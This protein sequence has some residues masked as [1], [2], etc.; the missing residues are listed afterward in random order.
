[1]TLQRWMARVR[2]T[3]ERLMIRGPLF[4]LLLVALTLALISIIGGV[5]ANA[6]SDEF[7]SIP[8]AVWWAFLHLTD[9]GYL[10]DDNGPFLRVVSTVITVLG[11]VVFLGA[12]IAIMTRWLLDAMA[13]LES[14]TTPVAA[15]NHIAIIG[16]TGRT[17]TLVS[18]L[19][20]SEGRVKRFLERHGAR[21]LQIA[22]LAEQVGPERMLE[23]RDRAGELWRPR[24]VTLRSGSGLQPE[25]LE[26]IDFLN[27]SAVLI[28]ADDSQQLSAEDVDSHTIKT[29]LSLGN[30]PEVRRGHSLPFAAVEVRD[31][32]KIPV[33]KQAYAGDIEVVASDATISRLI[34]QNVRHPGLSHVYTELLTHNE[35]CE[36]YVRDPESLVGRDIDYALT[37]FPD[38]IL[39][40][41]VRPC[42]ATYTTHLNPPAGF[43]IERGDRL[44]VVA[45]SYESAT[46]D[47]TLENEK[48]TSECKRGEPGIKRGH[49]GDQ[50]NILVLG[51]NDKLPALFGEFA[52]YQGEQF[53]IDTVST[54]PAGKR[55]ELIK[56]YCGE[57]D[58]LKVRHLE[59][60]YNH[61]PELRALEPW[62]Y[63][64][65]ILVG[66][67][68]MKSHE[69]ADARTLQGYLLLQHLFKEHIKS[70]AAR[71]EILVELL[72]PDNFGLLSGRPG[73]LLISSMVV[74]H[75]LAQIA[76]RRE[77]RAV[78]D[79][80]FTAGGAEIT[81]NA[82]RNYD[83]DGRSMSFRELQRLAW[84]KGEMLI[85]VY[86]HA[87][88][89][90]TA[91]PVLNP[92]GESSWTLNADDELVTVVTYR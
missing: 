90:A 21:R 48:D 13:R 22:I 29:L 15:K 64:R 70:D 73:E 88:D 11:C 9:P 59:A 43:T 72:D 18:E 84:A 27:A 16:W 65:I 36:I 10:G 83:I 50:L 68:R 17:P 74:S 12:L 5:V 92:P 66:S 62:K 86:P 89:V 91:K 55:S 75:M 80:L 51:W 47:F 25:H 14:G 78:F 58:R 77:L 38:G 30:H 42:D 87:A 44:V 6:G 46:P 3:L 2:F 67:S 1:M 81:F 54:R 71:P 20:G 24:Q 56:R 39:L 63:D 69:D 85:G 45:A 7:D 60:D 53:S 41:V 76:L 35:G 32:R 57:M 4:Q 82:A 19:L 33:T 31:A 49:E 28:P 26:R 40:G 61:L 37:K 23:L 79:E 8:A 34:A 52:T